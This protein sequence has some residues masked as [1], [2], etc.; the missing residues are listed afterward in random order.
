VTRR[1]RAAPLATLLAA[2]ALGAGLALVL[3][4]IASPAEAAGETCPPR[5]S[6]PTA[7][8]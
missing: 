7:C 2:L 8:A 5:R 1:T 3:P 6:A 4:L